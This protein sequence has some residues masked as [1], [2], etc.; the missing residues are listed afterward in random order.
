MS[1]RTAP[2]TA[3]LGAPLKPCELCRSLILSYVDELSDVTHEL[4]TISNLCRGI[5]ST[6]FID[7]NTLIE[8]GVMLDRFLDK[9]NIIKNYYFNEP[10]DDSID[11]AVVAGEICRLTRRNQNE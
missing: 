4:R 10:L 8:I 7:E 2:K 11:D 9:Q 1:K 3:H 5:T 6:E